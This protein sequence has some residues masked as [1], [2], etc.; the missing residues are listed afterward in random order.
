MEVDELDNVWMVELSHNLYLFENICT[1]QVGYKS[2]PAPLRKTNA[3]K[4]LVMLGSFE[5]KK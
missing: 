1:L 4:N 3:S 2:A 5:T